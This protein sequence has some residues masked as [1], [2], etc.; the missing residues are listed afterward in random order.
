[1]EPVER[2][3]P[4]G[5]NRPEGEWMPGKSRSAGE[6]RGKRVLDEDPALLSASKPSGAEES[7]I[8]RFRGDFPGGIEGAGRER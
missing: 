8:E 1:M 3:D 4:K 7:R 5:F 6:M 2:F